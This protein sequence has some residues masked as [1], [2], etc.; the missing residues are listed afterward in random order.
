M[1]LKKHRDDRLDLSPIGEKYT[2]YFQE[3]IDQL[4]KPHYN[5][6]KACLAMKGKSFY[7]FASG[8]A[9]IWYHAGFNGKGQVYTKMRINFSDYEKNKNIFDVLKKWES[10]I[11]A[12]FGSTLTWERRD[13]ILGCH[14]SLEDEGNI[15]S[16]AHVLEALKVWHI[17]NL[18]QFKKVFT[19]EIQL[20][21]DR[22]KF[23]EME[24]K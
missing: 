11:N 9:G 4:R 12:K 16:A 22:L 7:P 1:A 19:P 3:L 6:T 17:Q 24:S 20:A 5:F 18:L 13:D 15:E 10:E 23:G 2:L 14:I 21:L 8:T